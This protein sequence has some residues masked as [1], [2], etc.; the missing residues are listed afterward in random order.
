MKT[1]LIVDDEER[2]RN[3]YCR[4]FRKEGFEVFEAASAGDAYE[5]MTAQK[6]DMIL[7]DIHMAE[8]D[9]VVLYDA[10]RMFH[11]NVRVIVTSVFSVES[12]KSLIEEA[13]DYYDKS[14]S[15]QILVRKV[16]AGLRMN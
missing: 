6:L 1:I 8:V 16:R 5:V 9:G 10:I 11:R 13:A 14:E 7:L 15:I 4:T 2:I 12:Q 3:I